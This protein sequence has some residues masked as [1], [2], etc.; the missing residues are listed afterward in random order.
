MSLNAYKIHL[1]KKV[2]DEVTD[3]IFDMSNVRTFKEIEKKNDRCL[4][5]VM[6]LVS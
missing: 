4:Y 3:D 6:S 2:Y 5:F 1:Q